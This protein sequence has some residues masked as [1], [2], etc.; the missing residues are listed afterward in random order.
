MEQFLKR[1]R[2]PSSLGGIGLVITG[3]QTLA[4]GET[5]VGLAQIFAGIAA[6]LV[7]EGVR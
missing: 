2:E 4:T 1:V 6:I 7:P 5:V 3:V